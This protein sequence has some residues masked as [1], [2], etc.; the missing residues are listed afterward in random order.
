M[1]TER[2]GAGSTTV[3]VA[4]NPASTTSVAGPSIRHCIR[5]APVVASPDAP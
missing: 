4:A 2:G 1:L 5:Q 3:Q